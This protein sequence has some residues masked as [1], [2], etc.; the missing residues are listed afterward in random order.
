MCGVIYAV[1]AKV[2][3]PNEK[4]LDPRTMSC[5]FIGNPERSKGYKFYCPSYHTRIV[6]TSHARFLED[7]EFSVST[8]V[9]NLVFQKVQD[10]S[11]SHRE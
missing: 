8:Q 6:E 2:C 9:R 1:E 7:N 3:N 11:L 4:K 10:Q 5:F